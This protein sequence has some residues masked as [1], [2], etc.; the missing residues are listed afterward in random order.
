MSI[1]R[2]ALSMVAALALLGL[3]QQPAA[4]Q[5]P[6]GGTLKKIADSGHLLIGHRVSAR[7]FSFV[8][9]DGTITGY[10]I[11]LCRE[12]AAEVKAELGRQ[13]LQTVFVPVSAGDRFEQLLDG[14]IDLLCGPTTN[15]LGRQQVMDFSSLTFVSGGS[16][17]TRRDTGIDTLTDVDGRR[18]GVLTGT[19]TEA[20]L[21]N[22]LQR[23][24]ASPVMEPMSNHAAAVEAL[25]AGKIDAYAG[26]RV[27]LIGLARDSANPGALSLARGLFSHEPYALAMRQND[28]R[29]RNVVNR[30]LSKTYG[31]SRITEIYGK[32]F[33]AMGA[34][35]S[36]LLRSLYVLQTFP[37]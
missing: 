22:A 4:A 16:L 36:E 24:G 23:T 13:D 19:T 32:W 6:P 28:S 10:V 27:I 20:A 37:E 11:D 2:T 18:V 12:V 25:L 9:D 15:S 35:P 31:S 26:D 14:K 30:A 5:E 3:A 17:L 29:F 8:G 21:K 33:G 34:R 1:P 7:P